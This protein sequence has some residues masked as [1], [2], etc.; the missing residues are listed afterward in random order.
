[1]ATAGEQPLFIE[2]HPGMR[3]LIA[4]AI[5]SLILLLDEIDG[6]SDL[7]DEPDIEDSFDT[8]QDLGATNNV[9]QSK[10]WCSDAS[11]E[12]TL[13]FEGDGVAECDREPSLGSPERHVGGSWITPLSQAI[14]ADG[15]SDD[16]EWEDEREPDEGFEAWRQP[17]HLP[18]GN[19]S[20]GGGFG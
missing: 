8:E 4:D 1:M 20:H 7:E 9:D 18:G 14:W 6:D 3:R 13:E 12:G 17:A 5:E 15:S 2:F 11:G 10:A 19:G 16:R